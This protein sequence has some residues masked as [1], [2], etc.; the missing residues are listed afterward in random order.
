VGKYTGDEAGFSQWIEDQLRAGKTEDQILQGG[1]RDQLKAAWIA[2]YNQ[3]R[4]G[5]QILT[6]AQHRALGTTAS[7]TSRLGVEGLRSITRRARASLR[8]PGAAQQAPVRTRSA[9]PQ[10][11]LRATEDNVRR[12]RI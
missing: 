3:I 4:T 2:R 10:G 11:A 1:N 8:I 5:R 12:F 7:A 6:G 9:D